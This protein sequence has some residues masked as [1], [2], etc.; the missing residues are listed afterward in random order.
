MAVSMLFAETRIKVAHALLG[1]D[2]ACV[3]FDFADLR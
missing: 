3:K 2:E 1:G